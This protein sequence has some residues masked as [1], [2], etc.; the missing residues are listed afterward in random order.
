MSRAGLKR[1]V[2][3]VRGKRGTTRR[4]YW[5]KSQERP[6]SRMSVGEFAKKHG[7]NWM[8]LHA[9]SGAAGGSLGYLALRHGKV[10]G[11]RDKDA[12]FY[13]ALAG[14]GAGA[15]GSMPL[16]LRG[17][18][19]KISEFAADHRRLG[20]G[21]RALLQGAGVAAQLAGIAG[22][23][24]ATHKAHSIFRQGTRVG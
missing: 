6:N 5:M 24:Y 9:A 10:G 14:Y 3:I 12:M 16:L 11:H 18:A 2:K 8:A 17:R 20:R 15:Y 21:S 13:R 22:G 19:A 7:K 23:A 1:V 4:T